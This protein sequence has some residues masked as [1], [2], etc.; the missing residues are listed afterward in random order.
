MG[1]AFLLGGIALLVLLIILEG[2]RQERRYGRGS[3]R[4]A[5]LMRAGMLD[6]QRHLEPQR[7]VEILL[8]KDSRTEQDESG[9]P[10]GNSDKEM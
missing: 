8:Q 6:I 7:K 4:G 5:S 9:D 10:P 2:K 1:G 3:G